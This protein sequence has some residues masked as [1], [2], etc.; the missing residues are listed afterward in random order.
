MD[1]SLY[2][3]E[4]HNRAFI[5]LTGLLLSC[6][7]DM[8]ATAF[9]S[10]K[11]DPRPL[12]EQLADNL[13]GGIIARLN[14]NVRG[15]G[16]LVMRGA[17]L[18][19][20]LVAAFVGIGVVLL[21]L[22]RDLGVSGVY[23]M[24][25]VAASCGVLGWFGPLKTLAAHLVNPKAPRPYLSLSRATYANMVTLD[26]SGLIRL[27]ADGA[28]RSL[29]TR[30]AA[31]LILFV[32]FGFEALLIYW[33]IMVIALSAGKSGIDKGFAQIPNALA[34]VLLWP[35]AIIL[36]PIVMAALFFSGGASFFRAVPGLFQ[37]ATWPSVLQGG[38]ITLLCA[39][40]MKITLGGPRQDRS[41]NPVAVPWIGP[42]KASAK[43][44]TRD[45]GRILY[46][47]TVCVLLFGIGLYVVA[48]I[49]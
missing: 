29:L 1:A 16:V 46:V 14:R 6:V 27:S 38:A 24:L 11:A 19:L 30:L 44:N 25:V 42:A 5:A 26:E 18:T 31:P 20:L 33:P 49:G 41:G 10:G 37:P 43:L 32:L 15:Q 39:Y 34:R 47:Q 4:I 36:L 8:C 22:A 35:P 21:G 28:I 40:A 17:I 9:M 3:T 13:T 7:I 45:I 2:I 48:I 23:T 12:L